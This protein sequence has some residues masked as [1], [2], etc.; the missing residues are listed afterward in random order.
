[1]ECV[2]A[3]RP[4]WASG[5]CV[6][7]LSPSEGQF[8]GHQAL[9][10]TLDNAC[11]AMQISN[12]QAGAPRRS[13]PP[14]TTR[15]PPAASPQ[16]PASVEQKQAIRNTPSAAELASADAEGYAEPG[17]AEHKSAGGKHLDEYWHRG[18]AGLRP[19]GHDVQEEEQRLHELEEVRAGCVGALRGVFEPAH[20]AAGMCVTTACR[21]CPPAYLMAPPSRCPAR[22]PAAHRP[23]HCAARQGHCG[24]HRAGTSWTGH[25]GASQGVLQ[26]G[27][28]A[29][30]P[31]PSHSLLPVS[32]RP[33]RR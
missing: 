23:R 33:L 5:P 7:R 28:A 24:L 18:S 16:G 20:T 22:C 32:H 15:R 27:V 30:P 19:E 13:S 31:Q 25:W 6:A 1:M 17:L 29:R 8:C 3:S 14:P 4:P 21:Q 26:P 12:L 11:S 2:D 10:A 9:P